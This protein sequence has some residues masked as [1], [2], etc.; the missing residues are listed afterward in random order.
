MLR[1]LR[2]YATIIVVL[3][4]PSPEKTAKPLTTVMTESQS[5]FPNGM[6]ECGQR[7]LTSLSYRRTKASPSSRRPGALLH[8][9]NCAYK[10]INEGEVVRPETARPYLGTICTPLHF[11]MSHAGPKMRSATDLKVARTCP[12]CMCIPRKSAFA[13]APLLLHSCRRNLVDLR[14]SRA[15][16][17]TD[18]V[19][20]PRSNNL[21]GMPKLRCGN[22]IVGESSGDALPIVLVQL[23]GAASRNTN[24]KV[25][26]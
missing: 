21:Q 22:T 7:V 2:K 11:C 18:H 5:R 14:T 9:P 20:V 3:C 24:A 26:N 15:W 6:I 17:C 12:S 8:L 10:V 1:E 16:C 13:E 4:L 23:R 19:A 25:W